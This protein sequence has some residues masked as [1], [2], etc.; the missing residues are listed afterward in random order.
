MDY[1]IAQFSDFHLK[2]KGDADFKRAVA[3]VDDA[4]GQGADHLVFCGDLVESQQM[5]VVRAFVRKLRARNYCSPEKLTIVPGNHDLFPGR[6]LQFPKPV[7]RVYAQ[8]SRLTRE[9]RS[10][11]PGTLFSNKPYPFGKVLTRDVVLAGLDTTRQ[12]YRKILF[13]SGQLDEEDVDAVKA[14]FDEHPQAKHRVIVMHHYPY[15]VKFMHGTLWDMNFRDPDAA[16]VRKW[17]ARTGAT[18]VLCGHL[19]YQGNRKLPGGAHLV[20]N[21]DSGGEG[22]SIYMDGPS[23]RS[24]SLIKLGKGRRATLVNREFSA[25]DLLRRRR[26]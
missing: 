16:T 20:C 2:D 11:Q 26:R 6:A 14:L 18:L 25:D 22:G 9:A 15:Y 21:G 23:V 1:V 5:E 19:H 7:G 17:L 4:I 10:G 24:Y 12:G 8:F 13:G 3:M